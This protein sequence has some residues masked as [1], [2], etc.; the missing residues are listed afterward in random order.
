ME[1]QNIIGLSVALVD[2]QNILNLIM[3]LLLI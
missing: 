2:E 1:E 3:V